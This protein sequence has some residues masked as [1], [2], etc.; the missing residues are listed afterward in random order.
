MILTEQTWSKKNLFQGVWEII[1]KLE[2]ITTTTATRTSAN[3]RLNEQTIA[4]HVRYKNIFL[5]FCRPLLNNNV[6]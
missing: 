4:V 2:Q 5:L 3:K 1:R 6:K